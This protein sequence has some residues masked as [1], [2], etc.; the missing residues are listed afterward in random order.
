[1][2][3]L[4]STAAVKAYLGKSD[5]G[6]DAMLGSLVTAYSQWVRS[7][8]NRDF[9]VQSYDIYRSGR[10]Q[11]KL[12][13]PQWPLVTISLVSVD[14][15]TI[16]AQTSFGGYGY[17][18]TDR[19]I[20]L[21]GAVFAYGQDNIHVTFT[22][23]YAVVPPDIAQA[24]GELVALRY[25]MRDKVEWSSKS[26]AGETVSLVTK[27]MPDSVKTVLRQYQNVVPL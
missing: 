15:V 21:D 1:M 10:E 2:A 22:A 12:L 13:L 27:D 16:P 3:D 5:P 24:V 23:G 14:G 6:D 17:R 9:D 8:T 19:A 11:T 18:F 4:T 7:F 20:I 25:R 26:L